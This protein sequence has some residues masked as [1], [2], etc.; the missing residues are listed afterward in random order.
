MPAQRLIKITTN[1]AF[2]R[3]RSQRLLAKLSGTRFFED[4]VVNGDV[5]LQVIYLDCQIKRF[6]GETNAKGHPH[7]IDLPVVI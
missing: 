2:N 4:R 3:V 6:E 1:A 7:A 5:V